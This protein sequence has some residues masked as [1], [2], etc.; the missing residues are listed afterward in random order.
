MAANRISVQMLGGFSI[1]WN[2]QKID[3]QSNRMRKVW[4]L[5]AYLIYHRNSTLTQSHFLQLLQSKGDDHIDPNGNLK[6]LFYR[7]RTLLN[8][9]DPSAG[10]DLI[11]HKSGNYSWNTEIPLELD[12]EVFEQLYR[13]GTAASDSAKKLEL[14]LQATDLYSGDFL[15]KLASDAWAMPI[16]AY[17]HRIYLET[18]ENALALLMETHRWADAAA[19]CR[20]A[21]QIEPYS[22]SLYQQLMQCKLAEGDRASVLAIYEDMSE[23]LFSN[24]GVMPSDES[25]ALY[26]EANRSTEDASLP[27]DTIRDLS[28]EPGSAKGALFCEYDFF[29]LLYQAQAR[30]LI[31]NGDVIHIALF[32]VR[33]PRNKELSRRS[34]D[35]AMENLKELILGNLRQG[36]VVT[37]CSASQ[38]IVMLPQAN[39]E[40]SG[41]V[42]QRLIKAFFRQYPHSPID[43]HY[44]IHPLEPTESVSRP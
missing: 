3:D 22:E 8:Q 31:R 32:S 23:L 7:A 30:A 43:I 6:A 20:K 38:L 21:L 44:S 34:L 12:V 39:F 15:P 42:C 24:F 41:A 11:L 25:R 40:N 10:H 19:L 26:R 1:Q 9:L 37:Q 16:S 5:L 36:D 2:G 18:A 4:L 27:S 14:Y 35:R 17:Y 13:E 29:K 33:G 28:R